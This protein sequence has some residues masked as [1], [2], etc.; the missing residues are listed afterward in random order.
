M[1]VWRHIK[2]VPSLVRSQL[3]LPEHTRLEVRQREWWQ[4]KWE[5]EGMR[6]V[7]GENQGKDRM[8]DSIR[9]VF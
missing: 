8:L 9:R 1:C 6:R 4:W 3:Q 7:V 5:T 2:G